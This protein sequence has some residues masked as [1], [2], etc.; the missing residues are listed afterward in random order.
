MVMGICERL[1]SA[2]ESASAGNDVHHCMLCK[3]CMR[4]HPSLPGGGSQLSLLVSIRS[5][6]VSCDTGSVLMSIPPLAPAF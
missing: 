4:Y 3:P 5:V 2:G 6:A 1:I